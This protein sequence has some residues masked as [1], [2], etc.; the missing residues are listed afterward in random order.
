MGKIKRKNRHKSDCSYFAGNTKK[1]KRKKE[2]TSTYPKGTGK[3]W[4]DISNPTYS[5][6]PNN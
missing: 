4:F 5:S 1:E 3:H 6:K 2:P